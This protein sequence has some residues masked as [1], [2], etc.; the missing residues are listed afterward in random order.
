MAWTAPRTWV[1]GELVT[2]SLMNTH[3]RD[4]L[5]I[6]KTPITDGGKLRFD[7]IT[8][9]TTTA[10]YSAAFDDDLIVI[11]A[12]RVD[13]LLGTAT[14]S[15]TGRETR[16]KNMTTEE[17]VV[18]AAGVSVD[19]ATSTALGVAKGYMV[20]QHQVLTFFRGGPTCYLIT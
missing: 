8:F 4:N 15:S 3:L 20:G 17:L 6:L 18:Y 7:T 12:G 1:A 10:G 2:A 13:V 14:A 19:G 16:V 9:T 11:K 5:N